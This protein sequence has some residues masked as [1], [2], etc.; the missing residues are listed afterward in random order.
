MPLCSGVVAITNVINSN[1]QQTEKL[2]IGIVSLESISLSDDR[3]Y[4]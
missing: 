2:S 1:T 4:V 3:E